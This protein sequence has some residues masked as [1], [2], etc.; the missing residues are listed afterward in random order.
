VH[1]E[2][3]VVTDKVAR[4]FTRRATGIDADYSIAGSADS[5]CRQTEQDFNTLFR[6]KQIDMR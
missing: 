1:E 3:I 6:A 2:N 4:L 5:Q